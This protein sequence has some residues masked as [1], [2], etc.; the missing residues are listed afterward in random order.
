LAVRILIR[1]SRH[2][3]AVSDVDDRRIAELTAK[4][5]EIVPA[6][7]QLGSAGRAPLVVN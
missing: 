7:A 2:H 3:F 6:N 5:I 4:L 1:I